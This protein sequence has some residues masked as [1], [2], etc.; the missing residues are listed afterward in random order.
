LKFV[1]VHPGP[2]FDDPELIENQVLHALADFRGARVLEVGCGDGR[3]M[4]HYVP[5]A[6]LTVGLDLDHDEMSL[7]RSDYLKTW[8]P[9]VRLVQG[10]AEAMPFAGASFDLVV[11]GWSLCCV[12]PAGKR[13][14]LREC[15][16]VAASAVLDIRPLAD[17]PQV[18]VRNRAGQDAACGELSRRPGGPRH[19]HAEATAAVERA[20]LDGW[21]TVD[22]ARHFDWIDTYEDAG[23]LVASVEEDWED[24]IVGEDTSLAL[25]AALDQ[26]GRGAIPFTRQGIQAQILRKVRVQSLV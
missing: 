17:A 6:A 22:T 3:M 15:W 7:S 14:A 8:Q 23:E 18:W 4:R 12:L 2:A 9:R 13:P 1:K 19:Y 24:W 10:A 20:V 25:L 5:E 21:F 26:A 16:R 11:F